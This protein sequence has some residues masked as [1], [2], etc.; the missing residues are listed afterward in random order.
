[1]EDS[2]KNFPGLEE[3]QI[4]SEAYGTSLYKILKDTGDIKNIDE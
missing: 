1:M 2:Y 4:L 3:L